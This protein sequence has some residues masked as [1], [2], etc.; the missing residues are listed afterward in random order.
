MKLTNSHFCTPTLRLAPPAAPSPASSGNGPEDDPEPPT[1]PP[2]AVSQL[3][4][5]TCFT[6]LFGNTF[7]MNGRLHAGD[8]T[9]TGSAAA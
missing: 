7:T 1:P 3:S 9:G 2:P 4:A 5:L 8:T 6:S